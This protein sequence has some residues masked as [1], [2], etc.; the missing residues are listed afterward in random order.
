MALY[1]DNDGTKNL[2]SESQNTGLTGIDYLEFPSSSGAGSPSPT[3]S[4]APSPT[5]SSAC[6]SSG[7]DICWYQIGDCD[8]PALN[9]ET[10]REV[11]FE[12]SRTDAK[13]LGLCVGTSVAAQGAVVSAEVSVEMCG[14][15]SQESGNAETQAVHIPG[16]GA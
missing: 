6:G 9:M 4:N 8:M 12:R 11:S 14:E 3:P 10:C 15:I 2:R 16:S 7:P 13:A 1:V 5:P